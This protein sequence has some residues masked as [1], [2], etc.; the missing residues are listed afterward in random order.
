[1]SHVLARSKPPLPPEAERWAF[2]IDEQHATLRCKFVRQREGLGFAPAK[3]VVYFYRDERQIAP[4]D[5]VLW[6]TALND[7]LVT[8]GATAVDRANESERFGFGFAERFEPVEER[9][10]EGFF[11]SVLVE[12]L[13]DTGFAKSPRVRATLSQIHAIPP[14]RE[15]SEL[16]C[17]TWIDGL[18]RD[19]GAQHVDKLSYRPREAEEILDGAMAYYLDDRFNITNRAILFP[20]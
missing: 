17:R 16:E 18:I 9:Y 13:R 1:L 19:V 14:S 15:R 10:G 8:R 3:L 4:P 5:T 20:R 6:S 7:W 2:I 11:S 12:L